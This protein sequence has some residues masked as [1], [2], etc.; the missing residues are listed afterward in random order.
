ME[1]TFIYLFS[2]DGKLLKS[3]KIYNQSFDVGDLPGG[4]LFYIIPEKN[5]T[6]KLSFNIH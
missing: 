4:I 5:T 1:N 2:T 3:G 6:G